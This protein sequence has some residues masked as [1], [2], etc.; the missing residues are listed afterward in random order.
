M[1]ILTRGAFAMLNSFHHS[2]CMRF[3][4]WIL[5][6]LQLNMLSMGAWANAV[7]SSAAQAQ[8]LG[9][10]ARSAFS[11]DQAQVHLQDVFPDLTEDTTELEDVFGDDRR[12]DELRSEERRV[13]QEE[14][15]R[16]RS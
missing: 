5:L 1:A 15:R 13:G 4:A 6:G 8:A 12:T 3:L 14:R 9:L 11:F 16:A 7:Q 2:R 10:E